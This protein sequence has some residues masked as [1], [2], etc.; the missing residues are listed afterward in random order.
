[1][2]KLRFNFT[3]N[4]WEVFN[5]LSKHSPHNWKWFSISTQEARLYAEHRVP[6]SVE[7]TITSI[8]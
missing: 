6:V 3:T 8:L 4:T 1:M 2:L 5:Y 7:D